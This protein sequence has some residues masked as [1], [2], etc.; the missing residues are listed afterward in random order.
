L[1]FSIPR[2]LLRRYTVQTRKMKIVMLM[3]MI[4]MTVRK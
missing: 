2:I 1:L 4:G 3:M